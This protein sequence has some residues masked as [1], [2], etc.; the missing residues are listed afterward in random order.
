[1]RLGPIEIVILLTI[2]VGLVFVVR[3][4]ASKWW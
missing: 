3:R 2:V 4:F 1:M